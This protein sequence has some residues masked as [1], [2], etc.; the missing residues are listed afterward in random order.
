LNS[1]KIVELTNKRLKMAKVDFGGV[2]PKL[3]GSCSDAKVVNMPSS[4]RFALIILN[5]R[6]ARNPALDG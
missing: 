3:H 2:M 1:G 6:R 5:R 4:I